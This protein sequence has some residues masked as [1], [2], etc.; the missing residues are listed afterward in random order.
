[1]FHLDIFQYFIAEGMYKIYLE[2]IKLVSC[3]MLLVSCLATKFLGLL[4]H[5]WLSAWAAN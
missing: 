1:M 5:K 4:S 2:K 3:L